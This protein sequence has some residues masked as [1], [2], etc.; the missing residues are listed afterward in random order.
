[1]S[2]QTISVISHLP[3]DSTKLITEDFE[4]MKRGKMR[5]KIFLITKMALTL[6]NNPISK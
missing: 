4:N 2:L 3:V 1:M 6:K 5:T